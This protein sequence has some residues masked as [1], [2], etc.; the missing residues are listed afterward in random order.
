MKISVSM[1]SMQKDFYLN[2]INA[3]DF[4]NIVSNWGVDGVELLDFFIRDGNELQDV[5]KLL[6]EKSLPVS[7]FS[8][9]NDFAVE[10]SD[11]LEAQIAYVK[12]SIDTAVKLRTPMLRVLSGYKKS[13]TNYNNGIENV[14]KGLKSCVSYAKEKGIT[15]VL[16]NSGMFSGTSKKIR[17]IINN[18]A[19]ENLKVN[20]D[21]GNFLLEL[22][23]PVDGVRNLT[24]IISF[25]H[26]K[27]LKKLDKPNGKEI[28]ASADHTLYQGI[29]AGMGDVDLDQIV[30][31]LKTSEYKGYLSIEY[32][33]IDD[34]IIETRES[35]EYLRL[36][37][38]K[39]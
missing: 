36:L 20:V 39:I 3:L 18:V 11:E 38:N 27:D 7:A 19:A 37:L 4:I 35:T 31:I 1:W 21:T 29:R 23:D 28:I 5:V 32:E 26:F 16:E 25:V 12:D 14:L 33:G 34:C 30:K 6:N 22:E 10:S 13:S 17:E 15:L 9:E 8:I 24:D 2:K